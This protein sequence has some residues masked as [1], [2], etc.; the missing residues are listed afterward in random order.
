MN[1]LILFDIDGT[2]L[3]SAQGHIE[4][5]AVAFK[6]VYGVDASM[7]MAKYHGKTDQQIIQ[8]VLLASGVDQ[9]TIDAKMNSC[10][11][12][13]CSYFE[14]IRPYVKA[15]KLA[16]V[17]E[18]LDALSSGNNLLGL[19]TGNL[20]SIG[21]GKLGIAGIGEYFKLGGFGSDAMERVDLVKLAIKKAEEQFGFVR[22]DNVY[23]FG[24]APQDM[25][26]ALAGGAK[27]IGVTTGV[28]NADQLTDAGAD[29]VIAGVG[30][31]EAVL[32]AIG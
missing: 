27:A 7:Y 16:G 5:F 26:A 3:A 24:D 28:Y 20:E 31:L 11:E 17:H 30:D 19:V 15:D 21:Y 4:A 29:M 9:E 10:M 23:L 6:A 22:V 32:R 8:E 1:K 13:M 12:V 18:T 25:Q 2:L 14:K